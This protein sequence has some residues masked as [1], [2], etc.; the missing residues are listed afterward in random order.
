[1]TH[2]TITEIIRIYIINFSI[3]FVPQ[4]IKMVL[5]TMNH[6]LISVGPVPRYVILKSPVAP[7]ERNELTINVP[8]T[9]ISRKI[10]S[11]WM[12]VSKNE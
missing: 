7:K 10:I 5:S 1:M 6:I 8:N 2:K 11:R 4:K 9:G 12:P 3:H